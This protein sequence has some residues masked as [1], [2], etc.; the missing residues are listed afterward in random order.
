MVIFSPGVL[1]IIEFC[2]IFLLA[3]IGDCKRDNPLLAEGFREEEVF[4]NKFQNRSVSSAE[5]EQ[6]VDPQGDFANCNTLAV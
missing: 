1:K 3:D 6:I 2:L 4:S 5:T